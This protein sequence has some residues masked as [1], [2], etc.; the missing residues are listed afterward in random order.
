ME[1][2]VKDTDYF[3]LTFD[4]NLRL[5]KL[6][7]FGSPDAEEYQNAFKSIL[8]LAKEKPIKFFISDVRKQGVIAPE[9]RIWL[10]EKV[11]PVA[12]RFGVK[13]IAVIYKTSPTKEYYLN[14]IIPEGERI[15]FVFKLFLD[16][17]DAINWFKT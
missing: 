9:L 8:N 13:K 14:H 15:G 1:I 2:I 5:A 11:L 12:F 16:L 17:Q 4:D 10:N 3:T 7:W 6:V